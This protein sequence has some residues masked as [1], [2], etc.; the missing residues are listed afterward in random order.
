[1]QY[2]V[3]FPILLHGKILLEF[4]PRRKNRWMM[5]L[6]KV[7]HIGEFRV[8]YYCYH[9]LKRARC[10]KVITCDFQ[11]W[12]LVGV[13]VHEPLPEGHVQS[14]NSV[15]LV[16][17]LLQV[18]DGLPP[19]QPVAIA[20]IF[21]ALVVVVVYST[22]SLELLGDL[23]GVAIDESVVADVFNLWDRKYVISLFSNFMQHSTF[24]ES[25]FMD[26]LLSFLT[27]TK[28]VKLYQNQIYLKIKII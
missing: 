26:K 1:M 22:K 2:S 4:K 23:D 19:R 18:L 12:F 15:V 16:L 28:I 13:D 20:W 17:P 7:R 14:A 5:E 24:S 27:I 8:N 21:V 11:L 9:S 6:C 3:N 25:F 10:K